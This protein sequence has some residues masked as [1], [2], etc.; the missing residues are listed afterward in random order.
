M[1]TTTK[2]KLSVLLAGALLATLSA[3]AAIPTSP[4]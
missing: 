4:A 2:P 1:F 3:F